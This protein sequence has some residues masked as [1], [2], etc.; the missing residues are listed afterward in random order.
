MDVAKLLLGDWSDDGKRD[1]AGMQLAYLHSN[2]YRAAHTADA[3]WILHETGKHHDCHILCRSLLERM[4]KGRYAA[5]STGLFAKMIG[6]DL[7]EELRNVRAWEK[8]P[9]LPLF[10]K[11][12]DDFRKPDID[13]VNSWTGQKD[14]PPKVR[15]IDAAKEVDFE[16]IYRSAYRELCLYTHPNFGVSRPGAGD[17]IRGYL[18]WLAWFAPVDTAMMFYRARGVAV[19]GAMER[20]ADIKSRSLDDAGL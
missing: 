10:P 4:I 18:L 20:Y 7:N 13:L 16:K 3:F 2:A 12:Y 8:L 11:S 17:E 1:V 9:G 6:G 14:L 15:L 19:A 5:K